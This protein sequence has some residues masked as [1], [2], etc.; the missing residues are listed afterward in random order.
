[1]RSAIMSSALT[2]SKTFAEGIALSSREVQDAFR[3]PLLRQAIGA[4][5]V[6]LIALMFNKAVDS[7]RPPHCESLDGLLLVLERLGTSFEKLEKL[8]P[9]NRLQGARQRVQGV[10]EQLNAI[11]RDTN[12]TVEN[13]LDAART[14]SRLEQY[15]PAAIQQLA[16][17]LS[18]NVAPALQQ[19]ALQILGQS[20]DPTVP[21]QLAEAWSNLTPA[22]RTQAL[23]VWTARAPS[24]ADLLGRLEKGEIQLSSL[25]LTQRNLLMRYPDAK[26]AQRAQAIF[27]QDDPTKSQGSSKRQTVIDR[28]QSALTLAAVPERGLQV[29]KRA[30]ANCHRRGNVGIDVGPNLATVI[31]HSKEKLL[32]N[33]LD[34]SADIQP[35]Y[36]AYTCLLD[37]GEVLSGLLASETSISI[38]IKAAGGEIRTVT[39][40]EIEKLQN[41]NLSFMPEGLEVSI[42]PQEMA[43]LLAYLVSAMDQ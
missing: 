22:L 40:G 4:A 14:L 29:Y 26:I 9:A 8:E 24:T 31:S 6:E 30:C 37:S 25:D 32:R 36:Q 27:S 3:E 19:R 17:T 43:D 33:I 39:R 38:S 34:P 13:R 7:D 1:M 2:H 28:Y 35:G 11:M 18:P 10:A 16:E 5:D 41:L 15:R 21:A 20:A 23:D 42:T 12:Q